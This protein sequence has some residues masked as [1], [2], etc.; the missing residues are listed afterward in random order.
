M[1]RGRFAG[2]N[3]A[4]SGVWGEPNRQDLRGGIWSSHTPSRGFLSPEGTNEVPRKPVQ[5]Q[6]EQRL[7]T[8]SLQ[9]DH[10]RRKGC[11]HSTQCF[12]NL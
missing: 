10:K 12:N 9:T 11:A 1:N 5:P 2:N 7:Q 8:G 3:A 6:A 4:R